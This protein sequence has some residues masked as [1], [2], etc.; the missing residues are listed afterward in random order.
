MNVVRAVLPHMR[1]R[2]AGVIVNVASMGGR[3][4]FPLYSPYHGT[5]WAVEGFSE[6][7]AHELRR[8]NVHVKI[9]EPGGTKTEFHNTAYVSTPVSEPYRELFERKRA[10]RGSKGDYDT[11]ESIAALIWQAAND[12]SW[13]LRYSAKQAKRTLFWLRILGRDG[14][15]RR[16]QR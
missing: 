3:I 8:F 6:S 9:I 10:S 12:S 2:R 11:P 16:L 7:L 4:T 1:E 5:K 15:W 14:L 13:R